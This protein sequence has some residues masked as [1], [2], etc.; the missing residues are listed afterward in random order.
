MIIISSGQ[1][2]MCRPTI[3]G[4]HVRLPEPDTINIVNGAW[5]MT[6]NH[7]ITMTINFTTVIRLLFLWLFTARRVCIA[8]TMPWQD[9]CLSVCQSHAGILSKWLNV[10]SNF[11]HHRVGMHTSL[12][13]PY[14]TG[15]QYSDGE[16]HN[17]GVKC[18]GVWRIT[19]FS[20]YLALSR[21]WCKIEP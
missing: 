2:C 4:L 20:Q 16:P 10:S 1:A 8:R 21:K 19:I 9:V 7:H 3:R 17:G 15:W 11:F 14:Q 5:P 18:K 13:F 6:V 12:A